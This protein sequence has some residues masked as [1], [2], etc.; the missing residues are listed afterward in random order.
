LLFPAKPRE[1][2]NKILDE[3]K[4]KRDRDGNIRTSCSLR[5]TYVCFRLM[6]R[7][8]IYPRST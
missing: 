8:D 4:L 3:L 5:H 7:A 1:L 2:L 6:E